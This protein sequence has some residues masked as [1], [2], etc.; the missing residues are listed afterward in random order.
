MGSVGQKPLA[1]PGLTCMAFGSIPSR[2]AT[3]SL[4]PLGKVCAWVARPLT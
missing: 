3:S 1:V 2:R 4:Q